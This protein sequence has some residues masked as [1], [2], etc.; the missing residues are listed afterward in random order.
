MDINHPRFPS[1]TTFI[2]IET[3]HQNLIHYEKNNPDHPFNRCSGGGLGAEARQ[4]NRE[5]GEA[6]QRPVPADRL[7][8][9]CGKEK[10]RRKLYII[11]LW[12][13]IFFVFLH[14]ENKYEKH[15]DN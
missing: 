14:R 6:L 4:E 3:F 7:Q 10:M 13:C 11:N 15:E 8:G 12:I 5:I 2:S 9:D 1:K